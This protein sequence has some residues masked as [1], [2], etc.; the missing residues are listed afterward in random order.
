MQKRRSVRRSPVKRGSRLDQRRSAVRSALGRLSSDLD[1]YSRGKRATRAELEMIPG[2]VRWARLLTSPFIPRPPPTW[3]LAY[4]EDAREWAR[5]AAL[6]DRDSARRLARF[7]SSLR[8]I[9]DTRA[10]GADVEP[11]IDS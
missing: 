1:K 5:L 8:A 2:A 6:G 11:Q 3:L 7:L 10:R 4:S 9:T